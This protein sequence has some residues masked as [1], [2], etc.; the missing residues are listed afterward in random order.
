MHTKE[1]LMV[2]SAHA[3]RAIAKLSDGGTPDD[4]ATSHFINAP[5]KVKQP[6]TVRWQCR[7]NA[8]DHQRHARSSKAGRSNFSFMRELDAHTQQRRRAVLRDKIA[9]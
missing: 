8:S 4:A 9:R 2:V 7:H 1:W 5:A 3:Y 6:V